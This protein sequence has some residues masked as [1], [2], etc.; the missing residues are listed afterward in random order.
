MILGNMGVG[1]VV[2]FNEQ[3]YDP[4]GL[5]AACLRHCDLPFEDCAAPPARVESD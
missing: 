1:D 3:Q 5:E 2:R 4:A